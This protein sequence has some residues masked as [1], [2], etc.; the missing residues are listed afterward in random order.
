M[1]PGEETQVSF[2]FR[3]ALGVFQPWAAVS[4]QQGAHAV[5]LMRPNAEDLFAAVA[6]T[7]LVSNES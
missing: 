2:N 1:L 6:L 4:V 5:V 3:S 7:W